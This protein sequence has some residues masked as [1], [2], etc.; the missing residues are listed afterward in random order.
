MTGPFRV[1]FQPEADAVPTGDDALSAALVRESPSERE[2]IEA[3][4]SAARLEPADPDYYFLLGDALCRSGRHAEAIGCFRD[5]LRL[6]PGNVDAHLALGHAFRILGRP[7]DALT[8][9]REAAELAPEEVRSLNTLGAAL[10]ESGSFREAA[11]LVKRAL[12][13]APA[14]AHLH[15]NLGVALAGLGETAEAIR[16]FRRAVSLA[17]TSGAMYRALGLALSAA[18]D[19][20]ASRRA[21]QRAVDLQPKDPHALLDLAD[22]L[23]GQHHAALAEAAYEKALTLD[24]GCLAERETSRQARQTLRMEGLQRELRNET[25]GLARPAGA[26]LRFPFAALLAVGHAFRRLSRPRRALY[27]L[28]AIAGCLAIVLPA[29]T[30]L[31]H[32]VRHYALQDDLASIARSPTDNDLVVRDLI[33]QVIERR[34]LQGVIDED[35]VEVRSLGHWRTITGEYQV[36]LAFGPYRPTL[37]F[38][39]DAAEPFFALPSPTF[40]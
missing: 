27:A 6:H 5:A 32:V 8:S 31:P 21:H 34:G 25:S 15:A 40:R 33:R 9:F 30:L 29:A 24:P 38:R 36:N 14:Q 23:H 37:H 13:K 12:A 4:R 17:P 19:H 2:V 26:I 18:G 35:R 22:E 11:G 39:L 10:A 20:G 3:V 7:E 28:L 16:H 1:F